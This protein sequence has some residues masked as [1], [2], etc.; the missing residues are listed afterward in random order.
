MDFAAKMKEL[1]ADEDRAR[2][3]ARRLMHL[4]QNDPTAAAREKDSVLA[5]I[6][7]P[8]EKHFRYEEEHLFPALE[9]HGLGPEIDVAKKHHA[10]LRQEAANLESAKDTKGIAQAIY[11]AARLML[12]HTNF[13]GDYIYPELSKE[14][15]H[16]LIASTMADN[17]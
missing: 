6:R 14:Q 11:F 1:F 3:M 17:Q 12:H 2:D 8:I 5:F 15:W 9:E 4:A 10:A 13:E 16:A 7:G